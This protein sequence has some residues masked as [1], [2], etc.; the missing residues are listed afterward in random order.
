[1]P[2]PKPRAGQGEQDF[3]PMCMA[4]DT[5][6]SEYPNEE[7][8]LAVCYN[9]L[10]PKDMKN[11]LEQ[12]ATLLSAL[13]E[14]TKRFA[15][16][17][18][19]HFE[20]DDEDFIGVIEEVNEDSEIYSVRLYEDGEPTDVI[21]NVPFDMEI[22][23]YDEYMLAEGGDEEMDEDMEKSETPDETKA[24]DLTPTEEM[25]EEASRGLAW[26]KEFGRGGTNIGVARARD[27]SNRKELSEETI[28]RMNSYFARHEVDKQAEGFSE[29]EEGYPSAGRIA[30]ALWGG[31]AGKS[32]AERKA[33]QLSAD[34]PEKGEE[35]SRILASFKSIEMKEMDDKIGIIEGYASTYGNVDLGGD[36]VEKGAY[37]QT[38]KHKNNMV[39]LLLDHNYTTSAIAGVGYLEDAEDGLKLRGE[40]PLDVPE[41]ASAY[42]KIKFMMERGMKMG[43][44][45]GYDTIKSMPGDGGV[46]RLK[47]LALHEV[48]IT[49]FPMNTEAVIMGAKAKKFRAYAEKTVQTA[50]TDAPEGSLADEGASALLEE[51]TTLQA[52]IR[53]GR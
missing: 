34:E 20:M 8:R 25:A 3:I 46:R 23:D 37:T 16:G 6:L 17:Q 39:P 40:M 14:P 50:Q 9:A 49:P 36:V 38:L 31:D 2:I 13:E 1:M 21:T 26:R 15:S 22:H 35:K 5:M 53:N 47:E 41:V 48:S 7:Q 10:N 51:L 29:G 28:G 45:I 24:I 27:I 52:K 19:V 32:W 4:D 43:L 30:W 18:M 33:E 12:L 44:S 11:A 42:R